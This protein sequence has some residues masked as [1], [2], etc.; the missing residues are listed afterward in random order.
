MFKWPYTLAAAVGIAVGLSPTVGKSQ[1]IDVIMALPAQTLTF[2]TAFV[3]EDMGF[4]KKEGLNVTTRNLVGVAAPNAVLAGSAHFTFGTGPVYL[5]AASQGQR[6][7]AVANM[8]E[9]PMVELVLRKDVAE[10]V[11]ITEKMSI[12]ER[13]KRLKGLTIGIQGVGSIIHAWE[14]YV[15]AKGGLDVENDVRIA[16]MDPPAMLPAL[17]NKSID[18]YAT[19]MPFTTQA[20]LKGS[21]I[22]LASSV[23]DAPELVPFAY[24]LVYTV[25]E[26]CQKN[27]E[28]CARMARAFKAAGKMVQEQPDKVFEEVLKKRFAKMD[29]ELLKAAWQGTLRAHAKDIRVTV[30]QLENSQKI[31]LEAKLLDPKDALKS[32][33]GLYTD[34]FVK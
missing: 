15:V 34:E 28:M 16:P 1:Q 8:I 6:F 32:F 27:R 29:P 21:A 7:Y 5:R 14:R 9:R 13:A 31:N 25:P 23:T 26:T 18:G 11:G 4:Y 20:V 3:A 12:P 19:S 17:E 33:D 30:P 2:T 10:K 24:G 22:M